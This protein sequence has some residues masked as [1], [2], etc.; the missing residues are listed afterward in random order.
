MKTFAILVGGAGLAA[1]LVAMG[2]PWLLAVAIG[3]F[4]AGGAVI[5]LRGRAS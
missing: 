1:G 3:Y 2:A 4:L 5:T